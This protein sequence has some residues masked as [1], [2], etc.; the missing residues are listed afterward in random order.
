[1]REAE[2]VIDIGSRFTTVCSRGAGVIIREPSVVAISNRGGKMAL[3][4]AGRSAE[5][6]SNVRQADF[7][8]L[9]PIK[10]GAIFHERAAALMYRYFIA[11]AVPYK[12]FRPK[13]KV[14]ACVS[15]GLGNIEKR[16]VEKV[17]LK[18]G[19][20]EAVII[21]SPL[22]VFKGLGRRDSAFV[23]D[24]GASK[25]EIAICDKDGI[26]AG[27]SV[28]IGGDAINQAIVD[29]VIDSRR[30]KIKMSSAEYV[31]KQ[32][33]S[34]YEN[35]RSPIVINTE[36]VHSSEKVSVRLVAG[37]LKPPIAAVID[38]IVEV[39]YNLTAQIPEA[40]ASDICTNGITL[41]GGSAYLPG[42]AEY[43]DKKLDLPVRVPD[44]PENAAA[45]GALGF[46]S[47]REA[48]AGFLNVEKL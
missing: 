17:L 48:M 34:L 18:A 19:A 29:Y 3:L 31:K 2:L 4:E 39:A 36:P 28:D 30:C 24:I 23:I 11:K 40:I 42:L 26:I 38:K 10:E 44:M 7:Q 20:D 21:E 9:Y 43:I 22:A 1:M 15:C 41:C 12:I 14:I 27:C 13:I 47:D 25:S 45:V 16:D 33:A 46:F 5:K 8:I 37:E 35:D 6:L 32:I